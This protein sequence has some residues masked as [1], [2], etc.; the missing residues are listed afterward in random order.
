MS[1][2]TLSVAVVLG[3]LGSVSRSRRPGQKDA[4][5]VD[6]ECSEALLRA[7]EQEPADGPLHRHCFIVPTAAEL[8]RFTEEEQCLIAA[9]CLAA[10]AK[11][12]EL[13]ELLAVVSR[14]AA[15]LRTTVAR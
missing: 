11:P 1:R 6:E 10:V 9:T 12:F 8:S 7:R 4:D 14:A 2:P 13:T 15:S 3:R 5:R